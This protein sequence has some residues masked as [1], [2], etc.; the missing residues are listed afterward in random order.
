MPPF[1]SSRCSLYLVV[2]RMA[3]AV[4]VMM[5]AIGIAGLF[6]PHDVRSYLLKLMGVRDGSTNGL[7]SSAQTI[8]SI[9]FGGAVGILMGVFVAWM[10][11][12][13]P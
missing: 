5:L 12:R 7:L 2:F 13:G 9:R 10:V 11:W 1:R 8:P 4:F 6:F 3:F